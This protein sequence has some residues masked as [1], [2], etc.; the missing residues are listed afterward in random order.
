MS[1]LL[2]YNVENS[3][4]NKE[5]P[6]NECCVSK[7]LTGTVYRL[8]LCTFS[9]FIQPNQATNKEETNYGQ[10]AINES[11]VIQPL[12]IAVMSKVLVS[13]STM[14]IIPLSLVVSILLNGRIL[15]YTLERRAC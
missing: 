6:L 2:S 3:K 11:G 15:L 1:S 5:N 14:L 10:V 8:R 9:S 7:L 4:K 13:I 12:K